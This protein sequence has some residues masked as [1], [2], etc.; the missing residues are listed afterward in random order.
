MQWTVKV[1][2][3]EGDRRLR[4]DQ[5]V[6]PRIEWIEWILLLLAL[7]SDLIQVPDLRMKLL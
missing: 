3:P 1:C 2:R 6:Y 5:G 4:V 7:R